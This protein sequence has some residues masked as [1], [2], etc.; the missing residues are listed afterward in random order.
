MAIPTDNRFLVAV[1]EDTIIVSRLSPQRLSIDEALNLAANLLAL[2]E[3]ENP[4]CDFEEVRGAELS[5]D[6]LDVLAEV[7]NS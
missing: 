5:H 2:A 6:F 1:L 3:R 7:Q 4:P